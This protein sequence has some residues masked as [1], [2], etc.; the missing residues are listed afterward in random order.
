MAKAIK[1]DESEINDYVKMAAVVTHG[2]PAR[3]ALELGD[4]LNI[5]QDRRS[6][7]TSIPKRTL[8]RRVENQPAHR[9]LRELVETARKPLAD[10]PRLLPP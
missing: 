7:L 8:H 6:E 5:S 1:F 4:R 9:W 2:L 10:A 3:V